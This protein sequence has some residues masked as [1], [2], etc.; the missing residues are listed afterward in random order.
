LL[1]REHPLMVLNGEDMP[2]KYVH[3]E[4]PRHRSRS[5]GFWRSI[6]G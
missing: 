2:Y 6:F 3:V 1:S 4:R 5:G